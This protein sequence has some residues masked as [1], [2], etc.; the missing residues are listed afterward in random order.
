MVDFAVKTRIP[1]EADRAL[2]TIL[3]KRH[4]TFELHQEVDNLT[5]LEVAK[6][7]IKRLLDNIGG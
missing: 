6:V 3:S 4:D 7:I 5:D 2:E 1:T